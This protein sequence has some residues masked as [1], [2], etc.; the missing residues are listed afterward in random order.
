M[1]IPGDMGRYSYI[2]VGLPSAMA[3]TWGSTC[4]GAGRVLSRHAAKRLLRGVDLVQAL[5]QRGIIVRC[6]NPRSLGEEAS[7]AYKDVSNVVDVLEH[8]GIARNVAKTR[9]LAV[10]KG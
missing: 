3:E 1:L 4:H 10:I 6:Q 7:E 8:A 2:C 9:P 5:E